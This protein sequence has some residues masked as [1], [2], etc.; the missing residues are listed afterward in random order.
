MISFRYHLV[1]LVAVFLALALGIVVGTTALSGPITRDLRSQLDNAKKQRDTL[2]AQTKS[3]QGQVDDAGQFASTYGAQLVAGSLTK[4]NVLVI[5][6]PGATSGMRA[7]IDRE[8][9]ASG[10]K[11]TG[12]VTITKNYIEPRLGSG[13][14]SLATGPSHPIGLTLPETSD[15]GQLGAALLSYVLLGKGQRTDL[16]QVLGGLSALHMVTVETGSVA[17]ADL[18]VL[19]ARGTMAAKGYA[20]TAEVD[21]AG[22][23]AKSGGHVVVAGNPDAAKGGGVVAAVR[24]A[25]ARNSVSTVDDAD[26]ALGQV[27]AVLALAGA[28]KGQTGHYGTQ[29]GA[30]ALFPAP[31]K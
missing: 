14:N 7:G 11:V 16:T 30:D 4:K 23:L 26:G 3:L 10:A 24:S 20:S 5:S 6:L 21:L 17:P 25:T 28:A 1:S 19:L 9:A 8:L 22:A 12:R 29:A 2:A 31:P 13:I 18:V 15:A 27:S